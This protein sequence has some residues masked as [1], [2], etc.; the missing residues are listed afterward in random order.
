MKK[1]I[2]LTMVLLILIV[3]V[4]FSSLSATAEPDDFSYK[5]SEALQEEIEN[6]SPDDEIE[7][8]LWLEDIDH[9]EVEQEV[10]DKIGICKEDMD[11]L[12]DSIYQTYCDAKGISLADYKMGKYEADP[13]EWAEITE[14]VRAEV[15]EQVDSYIHESRQISATKQ[16][17]KNREMLYNLKISEENRLF[18]SKYSPMNIVKIKVRDLDEILQSD[19][20]YEV[21]LFIEREA[22]D[23]SVCDDKALAMGYHKTAMNC[24]LNYN[25][26]GIKIGQ[27]ERKK[28]DISNAY[29][30]S[31]SNIYNLNTS[32]LAGDHPTHVASI[33]VGRSGFATS[34][35]L[36]AE[37]APYNSDFFDAVESTLDYDINILNLSYS[38]GKYGY[39]T[40]DE[41]WVDHISITHN[42]AV[43][44]AAGNYSTSG[45]SYK[46]ISPGLAYNVMTIANL[47]AVEY[48]SNGTFGLIPNS[49][50]YLS[51]DSSYDNGTGGEKPDMA[52]SGCRIPY[53]NNSGTLENAG[54]G[55]SYAA[56]VIS[57][58]S[59]CLMEQNATL[60]SNPI[61][62]KAI[63]MAS[64][65]TS[66]NDETWGVLNNKQG[67]GIVNMGIAQ[68]IIQYS[69]FNTGYTMASEIQV[70]TTPLSGLSKK[71]FALAWEKKNI[72]SSDCS[73]ITYQFPLIDFNLEVYNASTNLLIQSS[74]KT[75]SSTEFVGFTNSITSTFARIKTTDSM[76][77]PVRYALAWFY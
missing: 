40:T 52:A 60:K 68:T 49:N 76:S 16:L 14:N 37:A 22:D 12:S 41:Q 59:A 8:Y 70:S 42:V 73:T 21:E 4:S 32:V 65:R 54:S 61:L 71:S 46:V 69:M 19:D 38:L 66:T 15:N 17:A 39:Y 74:Q 28:V 1:L 77:V 53:I 29:E 6:L 27:V 45:N 7:V 31:N 30:F 67:A 20:V 36:Y 35:H 5:M 34:A 75:N 50:W 18:E 43:S 55:T 62:L 25:G 63:L 51:S 57:G 64:C 47:R 3:S 58:I 44:Q 10:K 48:Y 56:P 11:E 33:M 9:D 23:C 13:E 24:N 2:S 26:T 72:A